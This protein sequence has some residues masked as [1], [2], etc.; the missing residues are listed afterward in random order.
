MPVL[1]WLQRFFFLSR[2]SGPRPRAR[3]YTKRAWDCVSL[4]RRRNDACSDVRFKTDGAKSSA[5]PCVPLNKQQ[6][7]RVSVNL[8]GIE[9][10]R[11]QAG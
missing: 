9:K 11:T 7:Q 10:P 3:E 1:I 2:L 5:C 8:D 6:S 4:T